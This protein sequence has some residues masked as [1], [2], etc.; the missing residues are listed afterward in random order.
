MALLGALALCW[1]S[2]WFLTA[3]DKKEIVVGLSEKERVPDVRLKT[4]LGDPFKL[5]PALTGKWTVLFYFRGNW[6]PYGRRQIKEIRTLENDLLNEN[7]DVLGI[8]PEGFVK[9]ATMS[10]EFQ[11]G[12]VLLSDDNFDAGLSMGLMQALPLKDSDTYL[13]AGACLMELAQGGYLIPRSALWLINPD[14]RVSF[15][16]LPV[17]PKNILA[18]EDLMQVI[19]QEKAKAKLAIP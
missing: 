11:T 2:G 4:G 16:H 13:N 3:Q 10:Q 8:S 19:R 7:V 12:F 9:T 6:C 18:A 14:G 15:A 1:G 5:R 17:D